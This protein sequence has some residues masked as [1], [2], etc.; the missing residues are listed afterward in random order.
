VPSCSSE[1]GSGAIPDGDDEDVSPIELRYD[2]NQGDGRM[3]LLRKAA[4]AP[5][6]VSRSVALFPAFQKLGRL[7]EPAPWWAPEI[8]PLVAV[9]AATIDGS[10]QLIQANAGFQRLAGVD[11][12]SEAIARVDR[13]FL[14]PT[15][16]KLQDMPEDAA[17]MI[18]QGL[19][20][21]GE[22]LGSPERNARKLIQSP[23]GNDPPAVLSED[24]RR[25][26]GRRGRGCSDWPRYT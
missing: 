10:G 14:Q 7:N 24:G 4:A 8:S 16:E 11:S 19:L 2:F 18:H 5:I 22:A 3:P 9:V 20:T 23:P 26:A 25:E 12:A 15:F 17:G 6:Q 13:L 1:A 21:F